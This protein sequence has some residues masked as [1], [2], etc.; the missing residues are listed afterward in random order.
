METY[1]TLLL[2]WMD[3]CFVIHDSVQGF[4]ICNQSFLS[5]TDNYLCLVT[6]VLAWMASVMDVCWSRSY[7]YKSIMKTELKKSTDVWS[8]CCPPYHHAPDMLVTFMKHAAAV[9]NLLVSVSPIFHSW[10]SRKVDH[11]NKS[12]AAN[13][14]KQPYSLHQGC[15][16]SLRCIFAKQFIFM[17]KNPSVVGVNL[18]FAWLEKKKSLKISLLLH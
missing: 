18:K 9:S 1:F 2:W 3:N 8:H 7:F 16:T 6:K 15:F 14:D 17:C 4:D 12:E 11:N 10:P 13:Q 5:D